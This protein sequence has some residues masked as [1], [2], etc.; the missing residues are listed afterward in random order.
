MHMA[1]LLEFLS[2]LVP[3]L[4]TAYKYVKLGQDSKVL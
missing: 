3:Y 1:I 4:T 2:G